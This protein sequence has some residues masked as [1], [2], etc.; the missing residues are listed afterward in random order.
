MPLANDVG[1]LSFELKGIYSDGTEFSQSISLTV[2]E[3]NDAP[4]IDNSLPI[5]VAE[6]SEFAHQFEFSDEED[7]SENLLFEITDAPNWMSVSSSGLLTGTPDNEDVGDH[8]VTVKVTDTGGATDTKTFSLSVLNTN[9]APIIKVADT[10]GALADAIDGS[11]F[12]H[13]LSVTDVDVG[14]SHR[15]NVFI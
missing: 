1:S 14:D 12:S 15:F 2:K 6:D 11:A 8:T 4:T 5:S 10:T 13:Q 3:I 9:D 7:G